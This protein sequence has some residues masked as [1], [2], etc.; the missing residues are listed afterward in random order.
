MSINVRPARH[1]NCYLWIFTATVVMALI[2]IGVPAQAS[3]SA[4]AAAPKWHVA[5][6]GA[7]AGAEDGF[8]LSVSCTGPSQCVAGGYYTSSKGIWTP[9][10]ATM[11]AGHWARGRTIVLPPTSTDPHGEGRITSISCPAKNECTAVGY[12]L[13]YTGGPD[14]AYIE[15]P[16]TVAQSHGV[17]GQ[18]RFLVLPPGA[19][20]VTVA[21]LA[22]VSCTSPGNCEAV[23]SFAIKSEAIAPMA[24]REV[25]GHWQPATQIAEPANADHVAGAFA[26]FN[27][28]SCPKATSCVAVGSYLTTSR[29]E[30]L[31]AVE[32]GGHWKPAAMAALPASAAGGQSSGLNSVS[33]SS[34][35]SCF[36]VGGVASTDASVAKSISDSFANG[37][38]G[39]SVSVVKVV[40]AKAGTPSAP[41]FYGVSCVAT[42]CEII[43]AYT[44]ASG[45]QD[46]MAVTE[47]HG[48]WG[49]ATGIGEPGNALTGHSQTSYPNGLSCAAGRCTAVGSYWDITDHQDAMAVTQG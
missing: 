34:T 30:A 27:A 33:C 44:T 3:T 49:K 22:G 48:K 17:W 39:T 35:T 7:P 45:A 20:L 43:G 31:T 1:V 25:N 5:E 36:A 46:W 24:D 21:T 29:T 2:G 32:S 37:H 11:T 14:G 12:N 18:L 4:V 8:L 15:A 13:G 19:A 16:F 40:P 6:V 38:W 47:S 10:V 9:M 28:V 42:S 23:G 41:W 26:V